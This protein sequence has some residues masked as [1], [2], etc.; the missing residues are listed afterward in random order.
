MIGGFIITGNQSKK[1]L[2]RGLGPSV[3]APDALVDPVLQFFDTN[4]ALIG[5]ND[6]WRDA[7]EAEIAESGAAPPDPREA[8]IIAL[9]SPNNYTAVLQGKNGTSGVGLF[10]AYD[11]DRTSNSQLA[12]VS[13]RGF[14]GTGDNILI[15]GFIV[16][17]SSSQSGTFVIRGIGP[18]LANAGL[19]G[20]LQNPRVDIYS[21]SAFVVG[22]DN[23]QD[24]AAQAQ[25]LAKLGIA[26][27]SQTE[28]AIVTTLLPGSYTAIVAGVGNTVGLALVEIYN[29]TSSAADAQGN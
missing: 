6:N 7:Q 20:T 18:S 9:L 4:G 27:T 3:N 22:N 24:D 19:T 21:G 8:A 10:E 26:P 17:S 11:L 5:T 2:L 12:N 29:V 25:A 23:W 16:D 15:G 13:T 28:A 1:V 14:V